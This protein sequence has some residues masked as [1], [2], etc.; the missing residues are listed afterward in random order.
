MTV[1]DLTVSTSQDF[2]NIWN[3]LCIALSNASC[4]ARGF[5]RERSTPRHFESL[6]GIISKLSE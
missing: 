1:R 6:T 3:S 2:P 5:G 4:M